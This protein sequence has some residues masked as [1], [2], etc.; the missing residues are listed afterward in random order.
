VANVELEEQWQI[1][2]ALDKEIESEML[3]NR[4]S[5]FDEVGVYYFQQEILEALM[6]FC[7]H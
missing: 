5:L 4:Y 3:Y 2:W 7:F 6:N 1:A